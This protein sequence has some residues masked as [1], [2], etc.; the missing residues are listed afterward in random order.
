[1]VSP[2]TYSVASL[3]KRIF[4]IVMAI[5]WFGNKPTTVQ[6][7]GIGLT[8]VGLYMYD[9]AE[10]LN[11]REK[12]KLEPKASL[13]PLVT[14]PKLRTSPIPPPYFT[15][16][17]NSSSSTFVAS[18]V[19]ISPATGLASAGGHMRRGSL[20]LGN[21]NGGMVVGKSNGYPPLSSVIEN[22]TGITNSAVASAV[23]GSGGLGINGI[24]AEPALLPGTKQE[25]TWKPEEK[26]ESA[27]SLGMNGGAVKVNGVAT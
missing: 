9:K 11:R 24:P 6:G 26:W 27:H 8:F 3:I 23:N 2:V 14:D 20:S 4:V 15:P 13:L 1:M 17:G 19:G 21:T 22:G 10:D 16:V 25:S 12:N 18:P 7:V 5:V